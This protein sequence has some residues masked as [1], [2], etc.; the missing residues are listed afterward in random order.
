MGATAVRL[1]MIADHG[2]A[3]RGRRDISV[4]GHRDPAARRGADRPDGA[5]GRRDPRVADPGR[6]DRLVLIPGRARR[7]GRA[8]VPA[9]GVDEHVD[10]P[11]GVVDAER[12]VRSTGRRRAELDHHPVGL[13]RAGREVDRRE[14]RCMRPGVLAA[15]ARVGRKEA[16]V[17]RRAAGNT[18]QVDH[19]RSG[20]PVTRD[21]TRA[22]DVDD[23]RRL[24]AHRAVSAAER[25]R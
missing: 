25:G 19:R 22:R 15:A 17:G 16:Q 23:H 13:H 14:G 8:S 3:A 5:G 12:R 10:R 21:L 1:A 2:R 6:L 7:R 11:G 9:V 24:R 20:G 4:P 18:R